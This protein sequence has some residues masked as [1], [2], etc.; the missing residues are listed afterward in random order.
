MATCFDVANF[1]LSK[2]D[3]EE[4][5][6]ISNLKLQKLV[7]YAQGFA[8]AILG[9][10]LFSDPMEAWE[11]GPVAPSLYRAYKEHGKNPIPPVGKECIAN[12]FT[13]DQEKILED[14]YQVYGQFSAWKLRDLSHATDPWDNAYPN[15][16]I[17][18]AAMQK[19]FLT[20]T[21]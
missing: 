3:P 5:E 4:G 12:V 15:G 19:Y 2:A 7:Y 16:T 13:E 20:L 18:H 11:H 8:L 10:P 17:T 1:F 14:V 9:E 6:L 21:V